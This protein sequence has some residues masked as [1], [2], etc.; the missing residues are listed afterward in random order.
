MLY[1]SIDNAPLSELLQP[2]S[3]LLMP[4]SS[5]QSSGL[6]IESRNFNLQ[7]STPVLDPILIKL[8]SF[9]TEYAKL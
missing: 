7:V 5:K 8:H 1:N 2:L 3:V 4:R 9:F 6:I